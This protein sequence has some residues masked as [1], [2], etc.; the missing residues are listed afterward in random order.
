MN[1]CFSLVLATVLATGMAQ[2]GTVDVGSGNSGKKT[3][4]EEVSSLMALNTKFDG[5]IVKTTKKGEI[6][7]SEK[8]SVIATVRD[9][10]LIMNI[11]RAGKAKKSAMSFQAMNDGSD[12]LSEPSFLN[13]DG[14]GIEL[15]IIN[16]ANSATQ[17]L[18]IRA[19][20]GDAVVSVTKKADSDFDVAPESLSCAF[21]R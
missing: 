21:S 4:S 14:A 6:V 20:E 12:L 7:T 11:S 2:A 10:K 19:T 1:K 16:N 5:N 8:C 15:S 13:P 3:L 9:G 17:N 18:V